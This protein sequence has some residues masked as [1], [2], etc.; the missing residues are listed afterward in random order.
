MVF[1]LVTGSLTLFMLYTAAPGTDLFSWHPA[2]MTIGVFFL[3]YNQY[4][5]AKDKRQ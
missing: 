4:I 5:S 1:H 3:Q 2:L